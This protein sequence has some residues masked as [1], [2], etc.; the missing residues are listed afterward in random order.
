MA[1]SPKQTQYYWSMWA[2]VCREHAWQNNDDDRRYDLHKN[3]GCP[4]SMRAFTHSHF[5][6]FL[7]YCR[8]LTGSREC[9]EAKAQDGERKRLIWRITKDAELANLSAGY[10]DQVAKDMYG[11][12]CWTELCLADLRNLRDL[13]HNRASSRL[14]HD[15]RTIE[16]RQT[17]RKYYLQRPPAHVPKELQP[18]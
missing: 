4:Q 8:R 3:A 1:L 9:V 12:A 18:F 15:T 7:S 10:L 14:G 2:A 17:T 13:M 16:A 5:D 11:L 6:K